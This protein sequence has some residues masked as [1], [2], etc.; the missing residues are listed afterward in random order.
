MDNLLIFRYHLLCAINCNMTQE[1][2]ST[3]CWMSGDKLVAF[4]QSKVRGYV[5]P[6]LRSG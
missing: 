3:Q 6:N 5:E 2:R 4:E 1:A